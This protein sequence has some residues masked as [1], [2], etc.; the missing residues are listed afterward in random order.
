MQVYLGLGSNLGGRQAN[1]KK[2]VKL[3]GERLHI[4]QVSSVYETEPLGYVEQPRFFNAVCL[5]QTE[6]GPLQ[7]LSLVKGIEASLGRVPGFP[8]APRPID[9]DII[10]YGDL[11]MQTPELTIP[12]PRLEKR[13]FVII[14]LLE[15]APDLRHPVSGEHIRGL[16]ARVGGRE[17]VRKIGDLEAEDV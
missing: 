11:I 8:N 15:I 13:A 6:L 5:A 3:L 1:L 4:E 9:V 10:F 12:H 14:P 2:A 7:L 17:G 16:A